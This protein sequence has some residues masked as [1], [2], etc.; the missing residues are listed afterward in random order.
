[1]KFA[2]Q[3]GLPSLALGSAISRGTRGGHEIDEHDFVYV[4]GLRLYDAHGLHYLTG[5]SFTSIVDSSR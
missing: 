3:F 4:K 1:M 5:W 2:L